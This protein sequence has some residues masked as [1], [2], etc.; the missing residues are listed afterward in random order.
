[1]S[2]Q[3]GV[4][5]P[6]MQVITI[7]MTATCYQ[8]NYRQVLSLRIVGLNKL[9]SCCPDKTIIFIRR[10]LCASFLLLL[11]TVGSKVFGRRRRRR[12]CAVGISL[13]SS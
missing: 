3:L 8:S 10:P 1:M 6:K 7:D 11:S 12:L 9:T 13:M 2:T 5:T 4:M